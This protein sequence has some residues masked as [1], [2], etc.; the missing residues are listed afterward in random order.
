[1]ENVMSIRITIPT[2]M[3][4]ANSILGAICFDLDKDKFSDQKS[5]IFSDICIFILPCISSQSIKGQFIQ[6]II[7]RM[8]LDLQYFPCFVNMAAYMSCTEY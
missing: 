2:M 5:N 4:F 3:K 1:M 7:R 8:A 6:D